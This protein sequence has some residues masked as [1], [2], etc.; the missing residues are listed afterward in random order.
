MNC[1][2]VLV[3]VVCGIVVVFDAIKNKTQKTE[4]T[5]ER[6]LQDVWTLE[7]IHTVHKL[8][9]QNE[10]EEEE[11]NVK[12]LWMTD[13]D[14]EYSHAHTHALIHCECTWVWKN[15]FSEIKRKACVQMAIA[16]L[17]FFRRCCCFVLHLFHLF[18]LGSFFGSLILCALF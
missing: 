8:I 13:D 17:F 10:P 9:K 14:I 5:V 15:F 4:H 11:K 16:Q 7:K 12:F 18:L 1:W 6:A 2:L 3:Y